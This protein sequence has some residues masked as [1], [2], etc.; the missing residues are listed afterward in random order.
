MFL[1]KHLDVKISKH[2]RWF[3]PAAQCET[4]AKHGQFAIYRRVGGE[5][6]AVSRLGFSKLSV[7]LDF[8]GLQVGNSDF[9]KRRYEVFLDLDLD[10]LGGAPL[11]Q[12]I[13]VQDEL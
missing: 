13:I 12:P 6:S 4:P 5:I 9:S 11:S 1:G 7:L 2:H 3:F 8:I 10:I